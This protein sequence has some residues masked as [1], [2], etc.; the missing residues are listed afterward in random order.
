MTLN[1]LYNYFE[2]NK[3]TFS[4]CQKFKFVYVWAM[5]SPGEFKCFIQSLW[6]SKFISESNDT[7]TTI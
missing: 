6:K 7:F 3:I 5:P 4:K 2:L 1:I